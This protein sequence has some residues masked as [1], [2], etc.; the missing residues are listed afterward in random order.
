MYIRIIELKPSITL[1][2]LNVLTLVT[3]SVSKTCEHANPK[4]QWDRSNVQ[5]IHKI[6]SNYAGRKRILILSDL[7]GSVEELI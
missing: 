2:F 3:L 5:L 7:F 4:A 1:L 6:H